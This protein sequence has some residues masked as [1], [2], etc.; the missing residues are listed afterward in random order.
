MEIHSQ[1]YSVHMQTS[2]IGRKAR[3]V[4]YDHVYGRFY[5]LL[6]YVA[7]FAV[8]RSLTPPSNTTSQQYKYRS[9]F[10]FQFF[11]EN[12][13]VRDARCLCV[14]H[15]FQSPTHKPFGGKDGSKS[16]AESTRIPLNSFASSSSTNGRRLALPHCSTRELYY[17]Y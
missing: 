7:S 6:Y 13:R 17:S 11:L 2:G 14:N 5:V 9:V 3:C 8:P 15:G 1:S 10:I 4:S 12:R 16:S